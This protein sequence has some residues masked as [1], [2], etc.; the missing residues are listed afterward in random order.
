MLF[1]GFGLP[2]QKRNCFQ[3]SLKRLQFLGWIS[4]SAADR[5]VC[6]WNCSDRSGG[7]Q[8]PISA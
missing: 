6:L 3:S 8:P 1:S 4:T 7:N 5:S 2:T